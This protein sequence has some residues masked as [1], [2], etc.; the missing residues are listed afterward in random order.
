MEPE[1]LTILKAIGIAFVLAVSVWLYF[2]V[3]QPPLGG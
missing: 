2:G 1:K 3:P